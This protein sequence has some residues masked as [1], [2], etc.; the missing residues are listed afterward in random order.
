MKAKKKPGVKKGTKLKGQALHEAR[1]ASKKGA[2]ASVGNQWW[3][4][5][6]KHGVGALFTDPVKLLEAA[7]EYFQNTINDPIL[8]PEH[9]VVGKTLVTT[10]LPAAKIFTHDGLCLYLGCATSWW[11]QFRNTEVGQSGDFPTAIAAIEQV[12]RT[13]KL[14]G[15]AAGIFNSMIVARMEGLRE[16]IDTSISDN[17]KAAGDL[18]PDEKDFNK[19]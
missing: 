1:M 6:S 9:K 19:K 10:V 2:A 15:A 16:G 3:K 18:F 7:D 11:R 17:R 8:I 4:L 13:Q 14:T 5:R 12:M